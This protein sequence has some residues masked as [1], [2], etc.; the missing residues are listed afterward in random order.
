MLEVIY[1]VL[2]QLPSARLMMLMLDRK[3]VKTA[4]FIMIREVFL[5]LS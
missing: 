1:F 3:V 5:Y 4:S 2:E